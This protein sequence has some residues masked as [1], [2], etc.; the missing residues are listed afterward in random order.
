[1]TGRHPAVAA[2]PTD[3]SSVIL[4]AALAAFFVGLTVL[5]ATV[6]GLL[7]RSGR[8]EEQMRRRLSLYTVAGLRP[9]VV[10]RQR[11]NSVL[12]GSPVARSA[13]ELA[14]RVVERRNLATVVDT[15]LEAAGL[16]VRTAEWLLIHVGVAVAS[17]LLLL[18]LSG[19]TAAAGALGLLLGLV[20]PWMFVLLRESRREA[21]FLTQLPDTLQLIASSLQAGYSLPQ[22]LDTVVR[23]GGPPMSVEFN[24]ALVE[25]RLGR[26][27]ED[28]LEGIGRRLKSKDFSW[29]VMA[30]RIQRDV[31]GNLAELLL[32]VA[33]TLRERERL[34]RQV[35][36]LSAEGRLSGIILGALPVVF[37]AYLLVASPSYLRPLGTTA[38]GVG[39]LVLAL[40]LL[41][42]GGFWMTRVVKVEV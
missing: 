5:V 25:S 4:L 2:I 8:P 15:R 38:L 7:T 6:L 28:S 32:T 10:G 17:A 29:V 16:P 36:T 9:R 14:G 24:R 11:Q 42:V 37:G 19:G 30:I 13:V 22:A 41:A 39:M 34:R 27:V 35:T 26:P 31:G 23:E 33:E 1:M 40:L 12:G 18:V 3:A 20:G 21:A